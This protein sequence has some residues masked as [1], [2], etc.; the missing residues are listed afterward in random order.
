MKKNIL[1]SDE[2]RAGKSEN[3][4]II[5]KALINTFT[6]IINTHDIDEPECANEIYAIWRFVNE[7]ISIS[8]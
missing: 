1:K 5:R 2:Y 4:E 3:S 8:E 7:V 6:E